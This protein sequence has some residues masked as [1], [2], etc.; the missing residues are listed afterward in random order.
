MSTHPRPSRDA[1]ATALARCTRSL[2]IAV[3][4][5][6]AVFIVAPRGARAADSPNNTSAPKAGHV[7]PATLA[8]PAHMR[9]MFVVGDDGS[10][11]ADIECRTPRRA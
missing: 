11:R 8:R 4:L 7:A 6:M 10:D 9:C 1:D 5:A 2:W 3:L